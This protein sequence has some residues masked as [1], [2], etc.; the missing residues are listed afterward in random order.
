MIRTL[1]LETPL[2]PQAKDDSL[3]RL[4]GPF[5][6]DP[7]APQLASLVDHLRKDRF[8]VPEPAHPLQPTCCELYSV[9]EKLETLDTA[10]KDQ[11]CEYI[12]QDIDNNQLEVYNLNNPENGSL[13][14]LRPKPRQFFCDRYLMDKA[15]KNILFFNHEN[16]VPIIPPVSSVDVWHKSVRRANNQKKH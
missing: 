16:P 11:L 5:A 13:Y 4:L 9:N 7:Q 8:N 15:R 6:Q 3:G 12:G 2:A 14:N 1:G 10:T